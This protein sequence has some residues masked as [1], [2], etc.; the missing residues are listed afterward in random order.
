MTASKQAPSQADQGAFALLKSHLAGHEVDWPKVSAQHWAAMGLAHGLGTDPNHCL[1]PNAL[2]G[3]RLC[4]R[5]L[6]DELLDVL[7]WLKMAI[8][9]GAGV[10]FGYLPVVGWHGFSLY[11]ILYFA[12]MFVALRM[13]K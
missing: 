12:L 10:T 6:Q 2:R 13:L 5:G 7:H 1:R 8:A 4:A 9:L 3:P 11:L